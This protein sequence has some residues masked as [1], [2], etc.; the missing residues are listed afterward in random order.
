MGGGGGAVHGRG[1][2]GDGC[3]IGGGGGCPV[4]GREVGE[5]GCEVGGCAVHGW[6]VGGGGC[7]VCGGGGAVHGWDVGGDGGGCECKAH[8]QEGLFPSQ[9]AFPGQKVEQKCS[10]W[11]VLHHLQHTRTPWHP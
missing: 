11:G 9:P 6:D 1:V 5:G 10:T 3:E 8:L 4:H 7:E 2:G